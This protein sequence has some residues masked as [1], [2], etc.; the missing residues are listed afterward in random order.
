MYAS[1][2]SAISGI[3]TKKTLQSNNSTSNL[4]T[5]AGQG[6]ATMI[7][8]KGVYYPTMRQRP[9]RDNQLLLGLSTIQ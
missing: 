1:N 3:Q 4:E 6:S 7:G 5:N 2:S 8:S 9:T